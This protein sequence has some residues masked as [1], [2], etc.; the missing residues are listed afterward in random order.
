MRDN[1]ISGYF[2]TIRTMDGSETDDIYRSVNRLQSRIRDGIKY[3]LI[4][5][6][7]EE[8]KKSNLTI[9]D[10]KQLK[11]GDIIEYIGR[12][13][14][15][16]VFSVNEEGINVGEDDDRNASN[17]YWAY[18]Q[19]MIDYGYQFKIT[20]AKKEQANFTLSDIQ[21]L[22]KG[23]TIEDTEKNSLWTVTDS[24]SEKL[25]LD[26]INF[27]NDYREKGVYAYWDFWQDLIKEGKQL[28]ITKA[29]PLPAKR[30]RKK[31][32][33]PTGEEALQLKKL[34]D[35]LKNLTDI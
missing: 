10:F 18:F 27:K 6:E 30:G 14:K 33:E 12:N 16:V 8:P 1:D 34:A 19:L 20:K 7:K 13:K 21:S 32:E 35:R 4:K 31:K 15:D 23:D 9:D 3:I 22:K 29:E 26:T 28:K 17:V 25:T 11:S 24:D 2:T 5:A